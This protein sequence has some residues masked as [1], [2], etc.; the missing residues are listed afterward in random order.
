[1]TLPKSGENLE[2]QEFSPIVDRSIK[3]YNHQPKSLSVS[4]ETK[5]TSM[6]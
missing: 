6:L 2:Q 3:L 4:Y 1:M 5:Y